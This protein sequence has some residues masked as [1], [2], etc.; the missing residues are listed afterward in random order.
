MKKN[1][2]YL[3]DLIKSQ[4]DNFS[5]DQSFYTS[6]SIFEMDLKTF[7]F[8]QWVFV[9][10]ISRIKNKGDYF[11]FQIGDESI[12]LIR[13][14][15]NKINAFYNVCRHRGS[16][17]CLEEEGR[18]RKFICPYH[19]WNYDLSGK[20][21]KA[22]MME[23]NFKPEN[24][25][26]KKCNS[27]VFEGLIF[28]NLSENAS[29]FQ[30]FINPIKDFIKLHGLG[31]AKIAARKTYPT[32]GNWKLAL[33]NFHECYH[34]QPSHPEYCHVHSKDYIQAYGAGNNTG[35]ESK[36]FNKKLEIW[37][38]K[39]KKLGYLTGE[40]SEK[41]FSNFFR[42]AERTP[43]SNGKLSETKSGKPASILMGDFNEFDGGYTTI[44]PSPFNSIIMTN[45]FATLF[46]FIPK[47]PTET[48][49]E[50]MWL[51]NKRAVEGIDY[52]INEITWMWD[53]TTKAD[54]KIIENNQKGVLSSKYEPG[55][56]S[57][58]EIGL[59]KLKKWYLKHLEL[60]ITK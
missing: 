25:S 4:K 57:K 49:V 22:R 54:K 8:N 23:N 28:I 10:H 39:V 20:L 41:K 30:N 58:M 59:D 50:L 26:L 43:F 2:S 11:L 14:N 56:L 36:K 44:G 51:V 34:C 12:I 29:D 60:E 38:K 19:A 52:N 48:E 13:E 32:K 21:L 53:E 40:Y 47:S 42:S 31:E 46:T 27:M 35:P 6:K 3:L 16:H 45:D 15:E 55:P 37:N 33:D 24:W 1:N 5:L 17:I 7:F 18:V 9:G